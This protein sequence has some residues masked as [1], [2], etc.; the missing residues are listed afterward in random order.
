VTD[1]ITLT[2]KLSVITV[3]ALQ[4]TFFN[5]GRWLDKKEDDGLIRRRLLASDVNPDSLRAKWRVTV[6]TGDVFGAGTDA[7][8]FII[9]FGAEGNTGQKFL[10]TP[11]RCADFPDPGEWSSCSNSSN[12]CIP[13]IWDGEHRRRIWGGDGRKRLYHY[14]WKGWKHR[15]VIPPHPRQVRQYI[16]VYEV[17]RRNV[18]L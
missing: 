1:P 15:P 16:L 2:Y 13:S 12:G 17:Y 10:D 18:C 7:N 11:G 6:H 5:C 9:I 4:T 14:L 3:P 8:V